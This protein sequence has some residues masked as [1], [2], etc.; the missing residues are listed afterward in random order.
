MNRQNDK[1]KLI[2][3]TLHGLATAL[4]VAL[5]LGT[6]APA[7][8]A[9]NLTLGMR[10]AAL[11]EV[12]AMLARQHRVNILLGDNVEGDVSFNLYDVSLDEAIRS[13]ASAGGYAVERRQGTY[14]ILPEDRAGRTPGSGF[15]VVKSFPVR[16]TD[17]A[18]LETKL[19]DYLSDFG[20]ISALPE[21]KL[22]VVEDQPGFVY[23]IS[24]LMAEL[25]QRPPQVLIEA[26]IL[27]ITLSDEQSYGIDWTGFFTTD[28]GAGDFGTNSVTP[29][30]SGNAG[31]FFNYLDPDLELALR[32]LEADGRVRNLASPKVVT[33]VNEEAE[34]IIGDRRGY[35]VTTTINQV[36]TESIEFLESGTIL[37][38]TPTI[39]DHGEVLL[40]IHPEVSVGTV[41]EN[42]IPSQTTTEVTTRLL[43]PSGQS[44]FIGGLMRNST[45]EARTGVPFLGRI[46]G[47][48]W[49]FSTQSRTTLNTETVVIITPR[50]VDQ[51]PEVAALNRYANRLYD[52][53]R[54]ELL[55]QSEVVE[56]HIEDS[57]RKPPPA[58]TPSLEYETIEPSGQVTTQADDPAQLPSGVVLPIGDESREDPP[59][60]TES[61]ARVTAERSESP[62]QTAAEPPA[63]SVVTDHE[64]TPQ[65]TLARTPPA[66]TAAAVAAAPPSDPEPETVAATVDPDANPPA[67]AVSRP[68]AIGL[69]AVNL[70]SDPE[71]IDSSKVSAAPQDE[72][73][74]YVSEAELNGETWHRLRLGF[75]ESEGDAQA[76]LDDW[77]DEYP[78]A[79][80]VRVRPRER[81]SA[82]DQA[83]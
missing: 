41:D 71:P 15:T 63:E 25:D 39:D 30:S 18:E 51:E 14:F 70:H 73:L 54:D 52:E 47:L 4:I 5:C 79:W 29:G 66:V 12:M 64:E 24:R 26:K 16:Y 68:S 48:R 62:A 23:R 20:T 36:T 38:V 74:L 49:L 57:F 50:I 11:D 31:F 83:L 22:L 60:Q 82:P 32:A 58:T 44:I 59:Q 65:E 81:D 37:R 76:A 53:E 35:A 61:A 56:Q 46:P 27:E 9:D 6:P 77:R 75:F 28:A 80:V 19:G 34:V 2:G 33:V 17:A 45:K 40:N 42:G 1:L 7:D 43:V 3:P 72:E 55:G 21:R 13:I 8:A 78:N 69:Y 10:E 67:A